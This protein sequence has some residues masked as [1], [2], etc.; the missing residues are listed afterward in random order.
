MTQY[1]H[2]YVRSQ[3]CNNFVDANT[4]VKSGNCSHVKQ[5][6]LPHCEQCGRE[7]NHSVHQVDK[8]SI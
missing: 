3:N 8:E 5:F 4:V 2:A 7:A 1:T 6:F